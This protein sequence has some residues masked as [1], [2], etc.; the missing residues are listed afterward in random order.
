MS[1][2]ANAKKRSTCTSSPGGM[3]TNL[4]KVETSRR[5]TTPSATAILAESAIID[6]VN[7]AS[8]PPGIQLSGSSRLA[9][10]PATPVPSEKDPRNAVNCCQIDMGLFRLNRA[11]IRQINAAANACARSENGGHPARGAHVQVL[12]VMILVPASACERA[13][14]TGPSFS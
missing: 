12:H 5:L 8:R 13:Y 4:W 3:S 10:P 7:A 9:M 14:Q 1:C 2:L 6:I 11:S